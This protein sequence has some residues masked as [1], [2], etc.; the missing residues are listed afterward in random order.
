MTDSQIYQSI[1][2]LYDQETHCAIFSCSFD[3]YQN[4][5]WMVVLPG[6][7]LRAHSHFK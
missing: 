2:K 7:Q 5:N 4:R 1:I 6:V 3:L